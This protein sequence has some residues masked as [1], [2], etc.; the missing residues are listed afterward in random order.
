MVSAG[1]N[2]L[3]DYAQCIIHGGSLGDAE[4]ANG[5]VNQLH[6]EVVI[7]TGKKVTSRQQ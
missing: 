5:H 2:N 1:E 6:D 4:V 7:A 3:I